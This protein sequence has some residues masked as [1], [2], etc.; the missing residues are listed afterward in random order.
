MEW[1][2]NKNLNPTDSWMEKWLHLLFRAYANA[3]F[4][5]EQP[6]IKVQFYHSRQLNYNFN[7]MW[8][9]LFIAK[10]AFLFQFFSFANLNAQKSRKATKK[11]QKSQKPNFAFYFGIKSIL[12]YGKANNPINEDKNRNTHA[13]TQRPLFALT[14]KKKTRWRWRMKTN[15]M[16]Q[17]KKSLSP[18]ALLAHI[19]C[20]LFFPASSFL[21]SCE[22]PIAR[23][24]LFFL[25]FSSSIPLFEMT[26]F[27]KKNSLTIDAIFACNFSMIFLFT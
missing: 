21:V 25:F 7:Q 20:L 1:M 18:F 27:R 12:T 13:H 14:M 17:Q 3:L 22:L 24:M 26:E 19:H 5:A 6:S 16:K 11:E 4:C 9:I 8:K 15:K 2:K 10:S 23:P